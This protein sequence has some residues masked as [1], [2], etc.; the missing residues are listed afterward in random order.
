MRVKN[1]LRP[2]VT[3]LSFLLLPPNRREPG[4]LP[5]TDSAP[6][7]RTE[8]PRTWRQNKATGGREFSGRVAHE[9]FGA[10]TVMRLRFGLR[11]AVFSGYGRPSLVTG[12]S[13]PGGGRGRN[14]PELGGTGRGWASAPAAFNSMQS[15]GSEGGLKRNARKLVEVAATGRRKRTAFNRAVD[16]A[17]SIGKPAANWD[18]PTAWEL[19]APA[20]AWEDNPERLLGRKI[21]RRA[22]SRA[23]GRK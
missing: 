22:S 17:F 13:L 3:V 23:G 14:K 5:S 1:L 19:R 18:V 7:G 12:G 10:G 21:S 4:V 11:R 15:F 20:S 8:R 6:E 9:G 16:I 2:R